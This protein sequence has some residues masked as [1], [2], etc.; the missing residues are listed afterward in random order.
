V[1]YSIRLITLAAVLTTLTLMVYMAQPWGDN[2]AYQSLWGYA[3][4]LALAVWANLPYLMIL[5]LAGK[6][7]QARAIKVADIIG[8]LIVFSGVLLYADAAFLHPDPQGG[9]VFITVPF[10]QWLVLALWAGIHFLFRRP[11]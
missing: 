3:G 8:T 11:A 9:L 4:L 10:Y 2:Y 6:A 7:S 5:F 1:I